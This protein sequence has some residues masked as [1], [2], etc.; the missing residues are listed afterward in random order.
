VRSTLPKLARRDSLRGPLIGRHRLP[1]HPG[2]LSP[3]PVRLADA[4]WRELAYWTVLM[5]AGTDADLIN[6]LDKN[7]LLAL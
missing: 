4:Q 5:E 7:T 3:P 1:Q 6:R 2:F